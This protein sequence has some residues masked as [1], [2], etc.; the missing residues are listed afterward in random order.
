MASDYKRVSFRT[1]SRD[2]LLEEISVLLHERALVKSALNK[3]DYAVV[4]TGESNDVKAVM[5][6]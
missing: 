2:E 5:S 4:I 1:N 6:N 3:Y